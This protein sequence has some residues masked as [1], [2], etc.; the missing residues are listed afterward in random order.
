[1]LADSAPYKAAQSEALARPSATLAG[2]V[3]HAQIDDPAVGVGGQNSSQLALNAS[4]PLFNRANRATIE[5]ARRAEEMA[6]FDL[7][8]AEQDLIVR[9]AQ[10]Y[11]GVLAARDSLDAQRTGV[12]AITEQLASA[13]RN[14]EVGSAT[15]TDTREAQARYD[16][17]RAQQLAAENELRT[18]QVTLDQLVGRSRVEPEPLAP[19]AVLAAPLPADAEAWVAAA[20]GAHP[21]IRKARL[22]LEMARLETEKA[23][24]GRLP[25]LDAVGSVGVG[26]SHGVATTIPGR[27][28]T[29]SIGVQLN[30]PLYDGGAL[31]NRIGEALALE[32]KARHDL[33]GARRAVEQATRVA[34]LALQSGLAQVKALEAAES[35]SRLALEAT[36]LGY[37]VGVRVNL[38][39]LNAQTQLYTTQRDLAR[40]RYDAL[41]DGLRLR[42]AAGELRASDLDAIDALLVH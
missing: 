3:D 31:Q 27:L 24:A 41:V 40:S 30:W 2:S 21:A 38:D 37:Q 17:A 10:A 22:A 29:A 8:S 25:T 42:Q 26:D 19:G 39:V 6:G 33:Q 34:F 11:F 20:D 13:R 35:S 32:D 28:T 1:A 18:R 15:I 16:L 4:V 5:R 36:Q 14:F 7:E 23:R 12:K 9:V